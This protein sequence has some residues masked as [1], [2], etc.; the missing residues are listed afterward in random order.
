MKLSQVPKMLSV[1]RNQWAP[2]AFCIS[3]KVSLCHGREISHAELLLHSNIGLWNFT[4]FL[5]NFF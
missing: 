5:F 4:A 3:F 2:L 1:L